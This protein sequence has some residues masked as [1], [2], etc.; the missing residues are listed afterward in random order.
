MRLRKRSGSIDWG[1]LTWRSIDWRGMVH[2]RGRCGV[3][4]WRGVMHRFINWRGWLIYRR[5]WRWVIRSGFVRWRMWGGFVRSRVMIRIYCCALILHFCYVPPVVVSL[6]IN[7]LG[8]TIRQSHRVGAYYN[9][10]CILCLSLVKLGSRI[11]ISHSILILIGTSWLLV[12]RCMMYWRRMR[13][14]RSIWC[15]SMVNWRRMVNRCMVNWRC[16]MHRSMV[17]YWG[18]VNWWMRSIRC[19]CMVYW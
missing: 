12:N 1:V 18:M 3:I 14:W 17:N 9:S 2:W 8:T 5:R 4:N 16:M 11:R 19:W 15:W 13:N 7:M 6:I 10:C